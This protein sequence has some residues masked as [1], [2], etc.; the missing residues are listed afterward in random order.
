M[1]LFQ[2][3]WATYRAVV[4]RGLMEHQAVAEATSAAITTWLSQR[5]P[6]AQ[7]PRMVDLGCGDLA[8]LAPV[9]RDLPLGAYTGLDLTAAVLPLAE[10]AMGATAYP[11]RW[12]EGDL[13]TWATGG[14]ACSTA[15]EASM[16]EPVDLLHSAFA[17]HHLSDPQ[18]AT[19]LAAVRQRMQPG[20]LFIWVD[21]FR[22]PGETREAYLERYQ[23]R[24]RTGWSVIRA[25]QREQLISHLSGFDQPADRAAIQAAAEQAG[26]HWQWGWN[27]QHRAEAMAVLTP[28]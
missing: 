21:V 25:E 12:L 2:Q 16:A 7:A 13:L 5:S 4:E 20:G 23:Q 19:F 22:E 14:A 3:Q 24:I 10:R 9:L 28:V 1:D 15:N 18:K 17:I 26:W 11:C 6:N 27:G 8:L